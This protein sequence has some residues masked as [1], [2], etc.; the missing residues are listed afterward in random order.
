MAAACCT[1]LPTELLL[2]VFTNLRDVKDAVRFSSTCRHLHDIWT[3]NSEQVVTSILKCGK[4]AIDLAKT[5]AGIMGRPIDLE[6][7]D[8]ASASSGWSVCSSMI[9]SPSEWLSSLQ[10]NAEFAAL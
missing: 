9:E 3:E 10:R 4:Q 1:N 8:A 6:K 5:E 2:E 7:P